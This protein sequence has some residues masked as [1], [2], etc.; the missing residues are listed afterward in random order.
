[1]TQDPAR[2]ADPRT[3]DVYTVLD[4]LSDIVETARAMPMSERCVVNRNEILDLLDAVRALLP[5]AVRRPR[6]CWPTGSPS[7]RRATRRPSD[8]SPTRPPRPTP[9]SEQ[10]QA[11]QAQRWS[12]AT[13]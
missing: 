8:C 6:S 3:A 1:M 5:A 12:P 9:W 10:G 11:H 4:D 13:R 2:I 7:S